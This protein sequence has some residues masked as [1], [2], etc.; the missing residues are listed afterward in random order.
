MYYRLWLSLLIS[1]CAF[2]GFAQI[3]SLFML[4]EVMQYQQLHP[5]QL[6]TTTWSIALPHLSTQFNSSSLRLGELFSNGELMI[7]NNLEA[8]ANENQI[9]QQL[10]VEG[11]RL[12]FRPNEQQ[13]WSLN[14]T[15][16]ANSQVRFSPATADFIWADALD[17]QQTPLPLRHH[18]QLLAYQEVGI[19][20]TRQLPNDWSWSIRLKGL[21]GIG[22]VKSVQADLSLIESNSVSAPVLAADYYL[23]GAALLEYDGFGTLGSTGDLGKTIREITQPNFGVAADIGVQ[24][25]L[26]DWTL[27][28]SLLDVGQINWKAATT[29]FRFSGQFQNTGREVIQDY[30]MERQSFEQAT[31]SLRAIFEVTETNEAYRAW[32]PAQFVTSL[33]YTALDRWLLAGNLRTQWWEEDFQ[34]VAGIG[35]RRAVTNWL[36]LGT[37]YQFSTIARHQLGGQVLAH[38]KWGQYFLI[39]DQLGSLWT[40]KERRQSSFQVG[41]NF[42]IG[43]EYE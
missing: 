13:Q 25:E 21:H 32:L 14:Y 5:A 41:L 1:C 18:I 42:L 2:A 23:R 38:W 31:D 19:G 15:L 9:D 12:Q 39:T 3:S 7:G 34:V 30:L 27:T 4:P 16:R 10:M 26:K 20:Y 28:I 40:V 35:I 22:E 24:A 37:T 43:K 8:L 36:T 6:S 29:H 17:L 33:Q 11:F